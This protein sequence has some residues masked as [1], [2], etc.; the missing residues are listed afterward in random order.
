M[1][2]QQKI[3]KRVSELSG[4]E[5]NVGRYCHMVDSYH[6][7]G[8]YF[9]EFERRFLNLLKKRTFEKRTM[10]YED[11]REVMEAARPSILEKARNM[12]RNGRF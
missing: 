9:E 6:L 12:Q 10:R 3:A 8:S 11:F 2:L 1:Q 5:I 4:K 7:Y